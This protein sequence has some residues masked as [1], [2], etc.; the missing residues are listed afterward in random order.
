MRK[1]IVSAVALGLSFAFVGPAAAQQYYGNTHGSNNQRPDAYSSRDRDSR[2]YRDSRDS[3]DYRDSRD[4]RNSRDQY[5]RQQQQN[6]RASD[7]NMDVESALQARGYDVGTVD[8]NI[9]AKSRAGIRAY[10]R[11]A[12]LEPNGQASTQLL[13][14]IETNNLR[15]GV[16]AS[17]QT[18]L[19]SVA[20]QAI[21]GL[22][23]RR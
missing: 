23:N 5:S 16:A 11:D 20:G 17:G 19:G 3:R 4:S 9:D 10:Q 7:I 21:Q 13:T 6:S 22:L 8:G 18:D 15:A 14:H 2:D 12:G 1:S